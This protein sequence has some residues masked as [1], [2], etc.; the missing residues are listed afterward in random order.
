MTVYV[1]TFGGPARAGEPDGPEEFYLIL[2]DNGRS[3]IYATEYTEA[4]ACI[5]CGACLNT[6]PVYNAV[7]GHSYGSVYSGPIGAIVTPLL[8]GKE[9]AVPL[10]FASSLCGA[11]KQAC[12]VDINI[13]DMLLR[14]RGDLVKDGNTPRTLTAA[15]K[16]W[17]TTMQSPRLF[18]L[19]GGAAK[20]AT[21]L[22]KGKDGMVH[23]LPGL[24]GNWTQ[25]RD[26][27]PF[28]PKSFHQLWK[29]RQSGS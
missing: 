19:A 15:I 12:P 24:L 25:Q 9:N 18:A 29:E 26:F 13:P 11:C 16:A 23:S 5:R 6:C 4:L 10:P 20:V 22:V 2:L 1:N 21:R 17:A 7:G 14:L 3:D 8:K 28:A 27:P